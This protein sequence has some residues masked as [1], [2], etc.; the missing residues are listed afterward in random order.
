MGVQIF[1]MYIE[2]AVESSVRG[3][4]QLLSHNFNATVIVNHT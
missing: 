1:R 3:A 2:F 4:P